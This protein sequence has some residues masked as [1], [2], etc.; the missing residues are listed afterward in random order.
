MLKA[1]IVQQIQAVGICKS[2][3]HKTF[4]M[5]ILK[6]F[7]KSQN[8]VNLVADA[9]KKPRELLEFESKQTPPPPPPGG[10]PSAADDTAKAKVPQK[11]DRIRQAV[12]DAVADAP[13]A[14]VPQSGGGALKADAKKNLFA[15]GN[16]SL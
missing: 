1:G 13:K 12:A 2:Q 8:L 16:T 7:V 3:A 11:A 5:D 6:S 9:P 10:G 4:L 14:V 15:F